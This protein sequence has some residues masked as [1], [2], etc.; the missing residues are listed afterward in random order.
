MTF[1][2]QKKQGLRW[3]RRVLCVLLSMVLL[4]GCAGTDQVALEKKASTKTSSAGKEDTYTLHESVP[5]LCTNWNPHTWMTSTDAYPMS[6]IQSSLYSFV[7]NDRLH[8]VEGKKPY[9]GYVIVPD[10]AA[11]DPVDVTAAV[12]VSHP[13]FNIPASAS[14]GFA[15]RVKLRDDLCW[16]DGTPITADTFVESMKRLLDPKLM[17]Y[18][19]SEVCEGSYS[20][21]NAGNYASAGKGAFVSFAQKGTTYEEY[22]ASGGSDAD[23]YVDLSGFWN[24]TMPDK[25]PYGSIADETRIR[26][27]AVAKGE[28][29]DYVSPKYL[30]E[31]YLKNGAVE[32]P[33]NYVGIVEYPYPADYSF[34]NV[35]LYKEDD[36]TLVF[37]FNH[38]LEGYYLAAGLSN[39]WLV[40]P[41]LYDACLKESKTASGSVWSSTYGTNKAT[42]ISYGPYRIEAY[43]RD[44]A[45]RFVRNDSWYGYRDGRHVYVDPVDKKQYDMYQTT[46]VDC[47]VIGDSTT[48]KQMFFAG[49]LSEYGLSAEDY[50]QYRNS[51]YCHRIPAGTTFF[52]ILNGYDE[53]IKKREEASDFNRKT[54]DLE[55]MTL[56]DFRR[57]CAVSFDKSEF[58]RTVNP[59]STE[60]YGL[61]GGSYIYDPETCET[62]R[63]TKQAKRTL[64]DFYV[65][66]PG[67]YSSLTTAEGSI[68]GYDPVKGAGL[69]Q[70]A[71]REALAKGYIT[72]RNKDGRSDQK[73]TITYAMAADSDHM[74]KLVDYMNDGFRAATEGTGFEGRVTVVKSAPLGN[75]WSNQLRNGLVDTVIGGW[76]GAMMDPFSL[77]DLYTD[78]AKAY[79]GNWFDAAKE[80]MSVNLD[81]E[82]VSMSLKDWSDAL[83]GQTV[84]CNGKDCNFGYGMVPVNI[85]LKI[86]A[87]FE[88]AI[89]STYDYI[90]VAESGSMSLLSQQLYYVTDTYNPVLGFGDLSYIRYNYSDREWKA[91]VRS[92]KGVL[93]Y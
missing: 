11:E 84:S 20:I 67:D 29:E 41:D 83:N 13:Q 79:N 19:A 66:D 1:G 52:I 85:R 93:Q 7:F 9:E 86:L 47:Q 32:A 78:P 43:Q 17:N 6:Y 77:T 12:R 70:K 51:D 44:K 38:A 61:I 80:Y 24:I 28:P 3:W 73:V 82:E 40:K 69:F 60:G 87:A 42:S 91:Y 74:T 8:P 75:E 88:K 81:G 45:M 25:T 59:S 57:A 31:N 10:M 50:E 37:A 58:V 55:T 68:T 76:S 34:E 14:S 39:N 54:T 5:Q 36:H 22:L 35:G 33:E 27:E 23:V 65:V 62:Y 18:R 56:P 46:H 53:I 89:L 4:A 64:C 16:D 63:G 92:Q 2:N 21:C 90:P 26:D 48:E 30:W 49:K 71:Y 15:F 72:D